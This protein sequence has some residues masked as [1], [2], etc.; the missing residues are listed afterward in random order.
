MNW[1]DV[2]KT[3]FDLGTSIAGIV[4]RAIQNGDTSAL[5]DLRKIL[6]SPED[7]QRLDEALIHA[8]RRKAEMKFEGNV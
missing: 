5:D 2:L 6:K 3:A 8:Q 1:G 7:I 4:F